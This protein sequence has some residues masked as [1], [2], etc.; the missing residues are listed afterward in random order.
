MEISINYFLFLVKLIGALSSQMDTL[1]WSKINV[2]QFGTS[3]KT[4]LFSNYKTNG[5]VVGSEKINVS[6]GDKIV[7]HSMRSVPTVK[8]KQK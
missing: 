3:P 1:C 4:N 2:F 5:L 8:E 7:L 6:Y